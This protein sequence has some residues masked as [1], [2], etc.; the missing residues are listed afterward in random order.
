MKSVDTGF[1]VAELG[2]VTVNGVDLGIANKTA[3]LD[4]GTTLMA[5]SADDVKTIH[6]KIPGAQ[7]GSQGWTVPCNTTAVLALTFG[8][9]AFPINVLDLA[10]GSATQKTG[11]CGS[12]I[13]VSPTAGDRW[14]VRHSFQLGGVCILKVEIL[15]WRHV[16]KVRLLFNKFRHERDISGTIGVN[17]GWPGFF[18]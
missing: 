16:P 12:G 17:I 5:A 3:L 8:G 9:Q 10:R 13:S 4:T 2:Q 1:W 7:Q 14:L 15:G 18:L 6:D 11:D